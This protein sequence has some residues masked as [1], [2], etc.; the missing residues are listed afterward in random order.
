[1][2]HCITA[3]AFQNAHAMVQLKLVGSGCGFFASSLL[4]Q[5]YAGVGAWPRGANSESRSYVF[6][7]DVNLREANHHRPCTTVW[8]R[9]EK[10]PVLLARSACRS[11]ETTGTFLSQYASARSEFWLAEGKFRR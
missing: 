2:L 8:E 7:H 5:F 1:M 3:F 9:T 11:I 4:L 6:L 10:F